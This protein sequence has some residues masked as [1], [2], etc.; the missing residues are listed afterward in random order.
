MTPL[1]RPI[2]ILDSKILHY[3]SKQVAVV[4]GEVPKS[5]GTL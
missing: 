4:H 1:L 5:V 3:N 2:W